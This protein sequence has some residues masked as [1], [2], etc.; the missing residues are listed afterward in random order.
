MATK[1]VLNAQSEEDSRGRW[2]IFPTQFSQGNPT[3]WGEALDEGHQ[4]VGRELHL[5]LGFN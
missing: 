2:N 3:S 5:E 1:Y 4:R